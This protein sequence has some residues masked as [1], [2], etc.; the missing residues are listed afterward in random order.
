MET[1]IKVYFAG[2]LFSYRDILY[3]QTL[4]KD[5]EEYSNN[6]Y[7]IVLPQDIVINST[8]GKVIRDIDF[9]TLKSCNMVIFNFDGLELDSGTV[10]EFMTAKFLDIPSLILRTD[11]RKSG[12]NDDYP[13]NL[14]LGYYPRTEVL[15]KG[16]LECRENKNYQTDLVKEIIEKL[17][18]LNE[19][20]ALV[21]R[22]DRLYEWFKTSSDIKEVKQENSLNNQRLEEISKLHISGELHVSESIPLSSLNPNTFII[23]G[24]NGKCLLKI[25]LETGTIESDDIR[26]ASLA[27]VVFVESIRRSLGKPCFTDEELK[28]NLFQKFRKPT[29]YKNLHSEWWDLMMLRNRLSDRGWFELSMKVDGI[30]DEIDP[31]L[32]PEDLRIINGER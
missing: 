5:I 20:K 27:G 23:N 1:P 22:P 13:W 17:N 16:V 24:S 28:T 9:T 3:N 4:K 11:F 12:D 15:I 7:E 2:S 14:M 21:G 29:N 10:A 25:D 32:T 30:I 31:L 6:K 19:T 18:K 26:D 8:E